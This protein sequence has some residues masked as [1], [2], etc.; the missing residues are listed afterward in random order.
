MAKNTIRRSIRIRD[1]ANYSHRRAFL[2][3]QN[4]EKKA[5][6]WLNLEQILKTQM[7]MNEVLYIEVPKG[8]TKNG[9]TKEKEKVDD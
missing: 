3:Q 8:L 4:H 7:N 9:K 1:L 6:A 2:N 5:L